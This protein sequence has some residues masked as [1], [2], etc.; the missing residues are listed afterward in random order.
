MTTTLFSDR[1]TTILSD[2]ERKFRFQADGFE[3]HSGEVVFLSG[4]SGSG[5]TLFLE[6]LALLRRPEDG[7]QYKLTSAGASHDLAGLWTSK[8]G[9]AAIPDVRS[10][11]FGIIPQIGALLPFLSARENICLSQNLTDA[12]NEDYVDHLITH[13]ELSDV[14]HQKPGDLSIG[15]RQR[16]AVARALAHRPNIIIAD[17]PTAAL[18][19]EAADTVLR[20]FL[21]LAQESGC[22]VLLSS[23]DIPRIEALGLERRFRVQAEPSEEEPGL[24]ESTLVFDAALAA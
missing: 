6:L 22:A 16:T 23:H 14:A 20:L 12:V 5:K 17:E 7:G 8:A 10:R 13:L 4:R 15:Q 18:D 19:P 9:R 11:L 3:M 2:K 21:G 24:I 1:L